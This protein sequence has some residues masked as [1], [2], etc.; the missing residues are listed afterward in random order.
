MDGFLCGDAPHAQGSALKVHR[1]PFHIT[2]SHVNSTFVGIYDAQILLSF[3]ACSSLLVSAAQCICIFGCNLILLLPRKRSMLELPSQLSH[4]LPL[5]KPQFWVSFS[6]RTHQTNSISG[7][8]II[9]FPLPRL[10]RRFALTR[11][12]LT[13][14]TDALSLLFALRATVIIVV[15]TSNSIGVGSWRTVSEVC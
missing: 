2:L 5:P 7:R 12:H 4:I 13:R 14:A 6:A 1:V 11:R 3:V 8:V 9:T 10:H 15:V